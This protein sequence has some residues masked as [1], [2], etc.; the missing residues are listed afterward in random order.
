MEKIKAITTNY[1]GYRF[2]SRLEAR[3][4]VFFDSLGIDWLYEPEGF[5]LANGEA[6]LPDFFLPTF[7]GGIWVEVKFPGGDVSK[8]HQFAKE[9]KGLM[10]ICEGVPECRTYPVYSQDDWNTAT[11]EWDGMTAGDNNLG[12]PNFDQ[13]RGENRMFWSLG[14][15]NDDFTIPEEYWE[16]H[17]TAAV[18]AAK[19]ARFEYGETPQ[20]E[21]DVQ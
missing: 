3:W 11:G 5:A 2:R 19:S 1:N 12:V 14:C 16:D 20:I 7:S 6:Y 10:W 15:E 9:G 8:A 18:N 17:Y 21:R 4:A 13:A